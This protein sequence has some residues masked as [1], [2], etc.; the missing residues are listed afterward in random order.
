ME[1]TRIGEVSRETNETCVNL[2]LN[3]DGEGKGEINTGA[4]FFDHMLELFARHGFF[5]LS[6]DARGDIEVD[7]HH[8]VEDTGLALGQAVRKALG[9]RAGITRYGF[10]VLPMDETL[11]TVSLDLSNRP[12]LVYNAE[13]PVTFVRDFNVNLF[14]EFFQAFA[15]EAGANLHVRLE[16]GE[17]PHHVVE[18]V[19]KGFARALDAAT[20]YEPRLG[21]AIPSTKGTLSE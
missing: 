3:L 8:L 2:S 20:R 13:P 21:G 15:N 10:F 9:N 7:Y 16:Y 17:E 14:K 18:A 5:D 6:V 11:V 12:Y 19:F 4:P 1:N